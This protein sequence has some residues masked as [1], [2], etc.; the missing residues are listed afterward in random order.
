VG[1]EKASQE[2]RLSNFSRHNEDV[3]QVAG[4]DHLNRGIR[5]KA[6]N[7]LFNANTEAEAIKSLRNTNWWID[8]ITSEVEIETYRGKKK[9]WGS[10]I[11]KDEDE[12]KKFIGNFKLLHPD[13]VDAIGAGIGLQ[14]QGFDGAVTHQVLK[15]A[16]ALDLPLIPIHEEYLVSEDKKAVIEEM[17]RASI[18]LVLQKAG[19]YGALNAK[20]TNNLGEKTSVVIK[21]ED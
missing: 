16:D 8:G 12:V 14:L 13:F 9:R 10:P 2:A 6:V 4:F 20:W 5:K 7:T 21:L 17:L 15:F 19:Q 18:Q 11:F 3:Y 1:Q